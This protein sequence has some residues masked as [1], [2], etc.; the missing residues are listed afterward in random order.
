MRQTIAKTRETRLSVSLE[1][2]AG[3]FGLEDLGSDPLLFPRRFSDPADREVVALF[4][5]LLAYGRVTQ[6]RSNVE[7]IVQALG[8]AP[9]KRLRRGFRPGPG[10][11][12]W[13]HRF[14]DLRDVVALSEAV[15]ETLRKEG[16]LEALFLLSDD[17]GPDL[18]AALCGF[19]A[20]L[21][22][23]ADPFPKSPGFPFLLSDPAK[24][25]A[26][27]RWNLFLRWVV[28][29]APIDLGA[30]TSVDP[31]RLTL[32]M[33]AH[34]ARISRYL[35]LTTRKTNDWKAAREAT[36]SL[37]RIDPDDPTRF[38]F[39]LCRL[40]VVSICRATPQESLCSRCPVA[41]CCPIPGGGRSARRA[42]PRRTA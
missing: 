24:G 37:A 32:P 21:R 18:H 8:P 41:D 13:K 40:G 3:T 36:D 42:S 12:G 33:D 6:I 11:S 35:R 1:R 9:A 15:G 7:R 38:D 19:A 29:G 20:E 14:N 31:A 16:S 2:L 39:A 17:G 22:R 34:V 5:A 23:R 10:L 30:W 4:A 28:R 26:S 25:A 27:K